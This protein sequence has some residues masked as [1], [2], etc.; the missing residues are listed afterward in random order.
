[1]KAIE[2]KEELSKFLIDK[3]T[4]SFAKLVSDS[5]DEAGPHHSYSIFTTR[6]KFMEK[7]SAL[8]LLNLTER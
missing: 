7:F 4:E 2:L 6:I 8:T 5:I 1:M 3:G